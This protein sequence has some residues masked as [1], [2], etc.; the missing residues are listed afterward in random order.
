MKIIHLR[1]NSIDHKLWDSCITQSYNQLV[2]AYSWYLDVVSPGWEA[3]VTENYEYIMPLPVKSKYKISYLVQPILTQQLGIFSKNEITEVVVDEFVKALPYFSYEI[4]LNEHNSYSKA[5]VYPNFKLNL[6]K[7]YDQIKASYSKN[8]LRNIEKANKL[9]L[10]VKTNIPVEDFLNFYYADEKNYLTVKRPILEK[11]IKAGISINEL[12][13][14]GVFSAE[15]NL[16]AGLCLLN[17]GNMLTN[18]LPVSNEDGKASSAMFLLIDYLIKNN[19]NCFKI[20]DFEGSK[21]DGVARFYK[22][23]GAKNHPYYSLKRLR[24][25]FL[26]NN[27]NTK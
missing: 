17:S 27:L 1:N 13:L 19:D 24:P 3:L 25:G 2:Y 11:L 10:E 23:F 14:Y 21:I 8:T 16:I 9:K 22:G 12:T 4:N 6:N 7:P 26:I 5:L 15:N 20:L 18:L